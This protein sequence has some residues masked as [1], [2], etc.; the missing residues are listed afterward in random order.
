M[1]NHYCLGRIDFGVGSSAFWCRETPGT[2]IVFLHGFTGAAEA[3]WHNA[4]AYIRRDALFSTADVLFLGYDSVHS[5]ARPIS[6]SV[7]EFFRK[8]LAEPAEFSNRYIYYGRKR[9]PFLYDR[10][11]VVAH[12]LG[13]AIMRHVALDL[14]AV[15]DA[16]VDHI[17]LLLFAPAHK[18]SNALQNAIGVIE[19]HGILAA[20]HA[21]LLYKVPILQDLRPNS[22]F[23]TDTEANTLTRLTLGRLRCLVAAKVTIG[24]YENTVE[25]GDFA[26]DP[27][28]YTADGRNHTDVCKTD[29]R[30]RRVLDDIEECLR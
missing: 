3:T 25:P 30:Y 29:A 19:G 21:G 28:S 7:L 27:P 13:G 1:S 18:G 4:S 6:R 15:N 23:I 22:G 9:E 11:V 26:Q 20:L 14:A 2:L 24:Q 12:S 5:R 16:Y 17:Q 10:V 8:L